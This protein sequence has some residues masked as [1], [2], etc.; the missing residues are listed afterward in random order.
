MKKKVLSV[1]F[2]GASMLAFSASAQTS[3]SKDCPRQERKE[4]ANGSCPYSRVMDKDSNCAFEGITLTTAQQT[5]LNQLKESRMKKAG[6]RQ[7]DKAKASRE[8]R[9]SRD[10]V[11]RA[12][13]KQ[14][15][16]EVKSILTPDQY[17]TFLE[18]IAVNDGPRMG[19]A[20]H[21]MKPGHRGKSD[22]KSSDCPRDSRRHDAPKH[23]DARK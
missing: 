12:E 13:R 7:Q 2:I 5:K 22:C 21:D 23:K 11:A 6:E 14:Y 17:V 16:S 9:E 10:S 19:R 3:A 20:H 8:R 1:F 15:L 4:I 18:N